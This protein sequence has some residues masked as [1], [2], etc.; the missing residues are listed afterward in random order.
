MGKPSAHQSGIAWPLWLSCGLLTATLVGTGSVVTLV[1]LPPDPDCQDLSSP[2]ASDSLRLHCARLMV[3]DG[4]LPELLRA[5]EIAKQVAATSPLRS[6][7]KQGIES[8]SE[9]LLDLATQRARQGN[10]LGAIDLLAHIPAGTPVRAK[11]NEARDLWQREWRRAEQIYEKAQVALRNRDWDMAQAQTMQL[12]KFRSS[13]WREVKFNALVAQTTAE[14][15]AWRRLQEARQLA[16]DGT[17][18]QFLSAI[19]LAQTISPDRFLRATAQAEISRWG[20][21]L[22]DLANR[23]FQLRDLAGAVSIANSIPAGLTIRA[24][25][26]DF[27]QLS[28]ARAL[29]WPDTLLGHLTACTTARQIAPGRP[30]YA[31]ASDQIA[32]WQDQ[33]SDL[34]RIDLG[35]SLAAL[36]QVDSLKAA[37]GLAAAVQPGRLHRL[38][39]QVLIAN[40][41]REI[42]LVEDQPILDRASRHAREGSVAGFQAAVAMAGQVRPGRVLSAKAQSLV[43]GWRRQIQL[44]EDR[45]ILERA[46]GLARK[47][48]LSEAIAT[49]QKIGRGRALSPD[50]QASI[51]RWRGELR[52]IAD[53][54]ILDRARALADEGRL[55][56][57]IDTAEQITVGSPLAQEAQANIDR[58]YYQLSPS[59]PDSGSSDPGSA[60]SEPARAAPAPYV[61][62]SDAR[63]YPYYY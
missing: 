1:R 30:L 44:V 20:R 18:P 9:R 57:A 49:A 59:E 4:G 26:E 58:W 32:V 42:Q 43:T 52:A 27:V 40:W 24:E 51:G 5:L 39:A 47:G 46:R 29:A 48:S 53:Q 60:P 14:R 61:P 22:L 10:L 8:W 54:Q 17:P 31:Q 41:Q 62:D 28:R 11:A 13:Y 6:E 23:R 35:Q 16:A 25:A 33:M 2:I 63:Y 3:Q 12:L 37:I 34:A 7:A 55:R 21:Q 50:A 56:R 45:P 36:R 19:R 38:R 15:T